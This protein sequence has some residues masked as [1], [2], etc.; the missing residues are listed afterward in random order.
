MSDTRSG[1]RSAASAKFELD[2]GFGDGA[3]GSF[4]GGLGY[5]TELFEAATMVIELFCE[6]GN[7]RF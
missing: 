1:G 7:L 4:D 5:S 3:G 6:D 2:L